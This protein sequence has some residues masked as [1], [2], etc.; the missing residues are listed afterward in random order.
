[1]TPSQLFFCVLLYCVCTSSVLVLCLH[2]PAFCHFC[3]LL[4]TNIHGPGCIFFRSLYFVLLCPDCHGFAFCPYCTTHT[5]QTS[6]TPAGFKPAI[7]ARDRLQTLALDRSATGIGKNRTRDLPAG[8]TVRQQPR[9]HVPTVPLVQ[10]TCLTTVNCCVRLFERTRTYSG[11]Y[12]A[13][14]DVIS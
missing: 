1:M 13:R 2:C 12:S 3:L 4:T 5:T 8:G 7:P 11:L 9:H 14:N 6:M 10:L